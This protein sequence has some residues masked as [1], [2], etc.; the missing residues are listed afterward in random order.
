MTS[1]TTPRPA[2]ERL[3]R[4]GLLLAHQYARPQYLAALQIVLNLS[5]NPETSAETTATLIDSD[6]Q[7]SE[8]VRSLITRAAGPGADPA[9]V[10]LAF[11]TFRGLA[12]SHL[13]GAEASAQALGAAGRADTHQMDAHRLAQALALLFTA[14][15]S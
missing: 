5:H 11:H 15:R 14:E 6:R 13:I 7:L 1:S 12:V 3:E 8:Q 2:A 10:S 4:L 9:T